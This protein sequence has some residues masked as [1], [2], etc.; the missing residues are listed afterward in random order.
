[1]SSSVD[2]PA[3][4][5][6]GDAEVSLRDVLH[7][8]KIN[9]RL[10]V[11]MG[12]LDDVVIVQEAATRGLE[13]DET[14][15]QLAADQFR[16]SVGLLTAASTHDWLGERSMSVDD[17]EEYLRR[18]VVAASLRNAVTAGAIDSYFADNRPAFDMADIDHVVVADEDTAAMVRR[19]LDT[20]SQSFTDAASD[21]SLDPSPG[22]R[23]G[24]MRRMMMQPAVADEVFNAADGDL[25][26]P[27]EVDDAHHLVRINRIDRAQLDEATRAVIQDM[28]FDAWLEDRR[29]ALGVSLDVG[30]LIS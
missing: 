2:S 3:I 21:H 24:P 23:V 14:E 5:R 27:I 6:V 1:M 9:D 12:A 16:R 11:L 10:G 20:G 29:M 26:G 15:L 28:I 13:A 8:L 17:L 22:G 19:D 18:S 4:G 7:T 25:V 30:P